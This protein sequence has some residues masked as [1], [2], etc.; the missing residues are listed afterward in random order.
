[1][2]GLLLAVGLLACAS[3]PGPKVPDESHRIP[4]N[5]TVPPEVA[6]PSASQTPAAHDD[7]RI[8]HVEWR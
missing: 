6:R 1:M 3:A 5:R 4:V 2:K 8:E 7:G